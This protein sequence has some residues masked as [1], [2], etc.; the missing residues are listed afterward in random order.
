M[1]RLLQ[2]KA[3]GPED[4]DLELSVAR[5]LTEQH[6]AI[7]SA[8]IVKVLA[9]TKKKKPIKLGPRPAS[10]PLIPGLELKYDLEKREPYPKGHRTEAEIRADECL[11]VLRDWWKDTLARLGEMN[12]KQFKS[13]LHF[14]S[15]FFLDK[16]VR[17][18]RRSIDSAAH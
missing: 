13:L 7:D 17:L 6:S 18:Y 12:D 16:N 4:F 8:Q 14:A 10:E 9:Q 5:G 2:D 11:L 1:I 3:E 15:A